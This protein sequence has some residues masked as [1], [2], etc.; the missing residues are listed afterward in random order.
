M[1]VS[2]T[3]ESWSEPKGLFL[4]TYG[5]DGT[6]AETLEDGSLEVQD[7]D[8]A[9][10]ITNQDFN[11]RSFRSTVVLSWEWRPGS[12]LFLVWQQNRRRELEDGAASLG[13]LL[14]SPGASGDNFFAVK[15]TYWIGL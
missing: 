11:V 5:T 4:R 14:G 1:V 10:I 15:L 6:T 3:S 12:T 9:F 8:D 2:S 13:D 7:G